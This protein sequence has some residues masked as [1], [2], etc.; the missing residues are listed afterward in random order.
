MISANLIAKEIAKRA[1]TNVMS[2]LFDKQLA[3]VQDK[4]NFKLARCSR[5]AGKSFAC[6][7]YLL[8]VAS[9][10]PDSNCVY[11]ALTRKSA[12]RILW[13]LLKKIA[14]ENSIKCA[15][16]E[17]ELSVEFSN[18]SYIY[19]LGANDETVSETLR[20]SPWDLVVIDEVASYRGH[21]EELI[22][23]NITP[24]LLD[25]N[26][27]VVLIGTPSSDF[28]SFFY[29][30]DH[31]KSWSNHS[32]TM[33]DNPFIKGAQEF[34]T[35]LMAKKG[36]TKET[37]L[38]KRE[39]YGIWA[40][41]MIDQVYQYS[42]L[43]N[44]CDELPDGLTY[45]IGSD[46]GWSDDKSIVVLGFNT[47][48]SDIV[49]IVHKEKRSHWLISDF[50]QRLVELTRMYNPIKTVIDPAAGGK[51]MA[52]EFRSRFSLMIDSAKKT[53]KCDYI[54]FFN[55]AMVGGKILNLVSSE[56]DEL[57]AEYQELQWADKD[58]RAE[59]PQPNHLADACLYAWREAY[60]YI[61]EEQAPVPARGTAERINH[62]A[63]KWE[64]MLDEQLN[65]G[66]QQED[67]ETFSQ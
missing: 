63:K 8:H 61:F 11:L 4:S 17:A 6:A 16:M 13:G 1:Q 50:G 44:R 2:G 31:D 45:I 49:Y 32:W 25:H 3:F 23:E 19:L 33:F 60:A 18:G 21:L 35:G 56:S 41:S 39:Y 34:L 46:V 36:W 28:T 42:P 40:R 26:G 30:A 54:E 15:F 7:R 55:A 27:T 12:K 53:A 5:R 62:D 66:S 67:W 58:K 14:K 20:G 24:A 65:R 10:T 38:V 48:E 64:T 47:Q 59:G 57:E 51:D 43:T 37:P 29:K 22:D 9:Q 52:E